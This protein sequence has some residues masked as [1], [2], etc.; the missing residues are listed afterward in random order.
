MAAEDR[1][2][3][4]RK[5]AFTSLFR[6]CGWKV[7][8]EQSEGGASGVRLEFEVIEQ[9]ITNDEHSLGRRDF[10]QAEICWNQGLLRREIDQ[11]TKSKIL[12]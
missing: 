12:D 1:V 3:S 11:Q 10:V 4:F 9:F 5:G 2:Q 8:K 6:S 7:L